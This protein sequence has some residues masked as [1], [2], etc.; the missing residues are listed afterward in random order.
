VRDYFPPG[1]GDRRVDDRRDWTTE[2]VPEWRGPTE[3][4][5][6]I[7]R[8]CASGGGASGV[9]FGES[10]RKATFAELYHAEV[11]ALSQ[12]FPSSTGK[13][14]D[15]SSADQALLAALAFWTGKNMERM[16][17]IAR[18]SKLHR[19]KWDDRAEY[20]LPTSIRNACRS[21]RE[22]CTDATPALREGPASAADAPRPV[23]MQGGGFISPH[24][25]I[26]L[27]A[28][29]VYVE[30]VN[31]RADAGRDPH[32][33]RGVHQQAGRAHLSLDSANEKTTRKAF[34]AF[35]QSQVNVC[36][37]A[38]AT[39]FRPDLA[40]GAI[41]AEGELAYV[42]TYW[43]IKVARKDGDPEPFLAHMRKL[44][45]D[46]RDYTIMLSYMCAIVQHPGVKFQWAPLIQG[47][48]GNG[49]S[50][51][52]RCVREAVGK[53]YTHW[54]KASKLGAQFNGWMPGKIFYAV[55]DIYTANHTSEAVIEE[56]K[57]MITGEELE[58]EGKGV[59][60]VSMNI[61]GNFIFN[62]NHK[63]GLRKT[64]DDRRFAVF[65]TPQQS[66]ADLTRDGLTP[67]YFRTLRQWLEKED[68]YAIVNELLFTWPIPDEF[69]P[70][71][72][73]GRAPLTSTT[74]EAIEQ[75]LGQLEQE[76]LESIARG[77]VGFSGGWI[78]SCYFDKLIERFKKDNAI[79]PNRRRE[80]LQSL[81]Y[82]WHPG[83]DNGRVN[84][85]VRPDGTKSKLYVKSDHPSIS[86]RGADVARAYTAA[87][88]TGMAA[89]IGFGGTS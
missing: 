52:S 43:P 34:E 68:G 47:T 60:Q 65:Y 79:P 35:T 45:P 85:V 31:K 55:E 61:C 16:E 28:G 62:T 29:C 89:T 71:V 2:P 12:A 49:K 39:M 11:D 19:P 67:A 73:A 22:V 48:Q 24:D 37:K 20:Y 77:D 15:E 78:S 50:T 4:A 51:L 7:R 23:P 59:D 83:L 56:L 27:F 42:N 30:H 41:V 21:K 70:A 58:I 74:D 36:P 1:D 33:A 53:R 40:P 26:E 72:D 38:Y 66:A 86:L 25:Q 76:V 8:A 6:L 63:G 81:G 18:T 82:D 54:P 57:P 13:A 46:H 75:G 14:Y 88:G 9:G 32:Q 17:R 5:D 69:N 64:R 87:Q 10:R 84:N 3:D 44:F 80:I